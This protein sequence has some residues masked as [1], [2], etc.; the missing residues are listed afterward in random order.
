MLLQMAVFSFMGL[1]KIPLCVCVYIYI[2]HIFVLIHSSIDG[3]LG[4]FHTF[5]LEDNTA[6]NGECVFLLYPIFI[7]LEYIPSSGV[8]E[9]YGSSIFNFVENHHTEFPGF[10]TPFIEEIILSPL[11]V[12]DI[13]VEN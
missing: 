13:F 10:L 12:L 3:Q 2:H 8:G 4:C 6:M 5:T 11:Y 9:S 7:S 1:N